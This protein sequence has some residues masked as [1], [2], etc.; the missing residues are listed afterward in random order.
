MINYDIEVIGALMNTMGQG[1]VYVV[2]QKQI[3]LCNSKAK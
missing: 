2:K 1:V 3:K